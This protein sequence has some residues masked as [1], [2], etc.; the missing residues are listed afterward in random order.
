MIG[1]LLESNT[2]EDIILTV[3]RDTD[4]L[5]WVQGDAYWGSTVS[6]SMCVAAHQYT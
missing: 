3:H 2:H 5:V 1:D 6:V 4:M